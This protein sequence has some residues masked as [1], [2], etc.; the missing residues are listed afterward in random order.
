MR[1]LP[2]SS[3]RYKRSVN[4]LPVPPLTLRAWPKQRGLEQG[5]L[6][7]LDGGD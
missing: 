7:L 4:H 2:L 5:G 6:A 3:M 1:R